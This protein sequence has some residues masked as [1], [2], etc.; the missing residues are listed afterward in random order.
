M[1]H[2]GIVNVPGA[3]AVLGKEVRSCYISKPGYKIV[4]ADSDSNQLRALG[5][6]PR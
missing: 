4:A 1:R 5:T 2:N 6:L 3:F